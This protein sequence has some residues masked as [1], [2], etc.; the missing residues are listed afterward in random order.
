[1]GLD[2]ALGLVPG[3][4]DEDDPPPVAERAAAPVADFLA[5]VYPEPEPEPE[6]TPDWVR[7]PG[8]QVVS[9]LMQR[10]R[11]IG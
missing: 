8:R 5:G 11:K 1:M 10:G 9:R 4:L 2:L 3:L 6:P 7:L